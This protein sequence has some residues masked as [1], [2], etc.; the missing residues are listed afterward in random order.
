MN[1]ALNG[2][3]A[4]ACIAVIAASGLFIIDRNEKMRAEAI[5]ASDRAAVIR[6]TL[7]AQAQAQQDAIEAAHQKAI[8]D[9]RRDLSAYDNQGATLAFVVRVQNAGQPLTGDAMAAQVQ[10]C[11]ELIAG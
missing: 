2:L 9:C 1:A 8:S 4:I 11:R 3:I 10:G 6:M 5:A 7:E